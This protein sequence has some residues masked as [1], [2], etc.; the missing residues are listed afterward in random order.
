MVHVCEHGQGT[1]LP[2]FGGD[3]STNNWPNGTSHG[4]DG[5][6]QA[7]PHSPIPLRE[8]V[9]NADIDKSLHATGTKTLN[10]PREDEGLQ[11]VYHGTK[12]TANEEYGARNN[13]ETLST[14]NIRDLAPR[15]HTGCAGK[16]V[17]QVKDC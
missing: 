14:E 1:D 11:I 5:R 4:P 6:H 16:D 12:Q 17:L 3:C 15:G 10:G 2:G 13:E 8:E 9:A 7:I